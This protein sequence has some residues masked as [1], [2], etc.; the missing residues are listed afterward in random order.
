MAKNKK[1]EEPPKGS[2]AWMATFSD[3]MNLLLCFFVLL[4]S[5]S[6]VDESK[7]EALMKSLADT[8]SIFSGGGSSFDE[9]VLISNGASQLSVLDDYFT[10]AGQTDDGENPD[11]VNQSDEGGE[12]SDNLD[13]GV[14]PVPSG[15]ALPSPTPGGNQS[16]DDSTQGTATP[17][18]SP[19][20]GGNPSQGEDPSVGKLSPTPSPTPG[21]NPSEGE[22]HSAGKVSPTPSPTPG[23]AEQ[24]REEN[25]QQ[26]GLIYDEVI[27]MAD[28][29][30]ISEFLEIGI[31]TEKYEYIQIEIKGS[32]LFDSGEAV[33]KEEALPIITKLADIL[34]Q[35]HN[36]KVE[37]I[38]H[39][40]NI[41][42]NP[43][44]AQF[45]NNEML[46]AGRALAVAECLE[47]KGLSWKNLYFSGRGEHDPIA[48]NGTSEGRAK[49]RRVE[50]RLYNLKNSN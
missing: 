3:L 40:D 19:T 20:P 39:T 34:K 5:M 48:D 45:P 43:D 35:Y 44:N 2:P 49:N 8:F 15:A 16:G 42:Q 32:V 24:E 4:F 37:V 41:V 38:G 29:Y 28:K 27:G 13:P 36:Y 25:K 21:G 26:S 47:E 14:S 23:Y 1:P 12:S 6:S 46:S 18:P 50:I 22:D 31:D 17:T 30:N 9:G 11:N 10:T 33:L 7:A